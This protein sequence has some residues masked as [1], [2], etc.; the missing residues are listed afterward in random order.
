MISE[1][2]TNLVGR[3]SEAHSFSLCFP[4]LIGPVVWQWWATKV[5]V[6]NWQDLHLA[7]EQGRVGGVRWQRKRLRNTLMLFQAEFEFASKPTRNP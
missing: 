2:N 6:S 7:F 4:Y 5:V 1:G 3:M